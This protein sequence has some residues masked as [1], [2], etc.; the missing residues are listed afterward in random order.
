MVLNIQ[1]S[2]HQTSLLELV[3]LLEE[4]RK[5]II[6]N[7]QHLQEKYH[8]QG[9]K[10]I[11]GYRD[12][13]GD[14]FE[15]L[16]KAESMDSGEY[17]RIVSFKLNRHTA[18]LNMLITRP[19]KLVKSADGNP[20]AE[21]AGL[22][23]TNVE[24]FN[25]YTIVSNGEVNLKSLQI[26]ISNKK[27]FELLKE[28]GVIETENYDFRKEY[29]IQLDNLPLVPE[30]VTYANLDGVFDELAQI[31]ILSSILSAL[32]RKKSD[33]YTPE[34]LQE[35][36]KHYLSKNLHLNFPTT[37]EYRDLHAALANGT[38]DFRKT[39]KVDIG[40]KE[41]LNLGQ[42]HSANKFLDRMYDVYLEGS[43]KK[44]NKPTF[45]AILDDNVVFYHKTLSSRT[46]I[47]KVD[48]LMQQIF[49][50]FLGIEDN[51]KVAAILS[52]VGAD[53]LMPMLQEKWHG[54]KV[55]R[56][57]FVAA[58]TAASDKLE[59]Y[60]EKIYREKINPVVF[61]IGSTGKLPDAMD[62]QAQTADIIGA[63]YPDLHFSKDE[64]EGIFFEVGNTI[65]SV[66]AKNE[67]Y[68]VKTPA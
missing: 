35:L 1:K 41:I 42:L 17:V 7:F 30:R 67:Y 65:I 68:T 66:Y 10:R 23:F 54:E 52:K 57:E 19:V 32:L 59:D 56:D 40:S 55:N 63:K 5:H 27:V 8:R 15:P 12:E 11:K 18:T 44:L 3:K 61:Y 51:C 34:Q 49:D 33:I 21:V 38:V 62:V 20:L 13:K 36:E 47:T 43:G 60:V 16:I 6:V 2:P 58:L 53:H 45:D 37:T 26:K 25:N 48:E 14:L 31:K 29:T 22:L 24:T 46:K 28:K 50:D 39:Y 4:N 64:R 9:L